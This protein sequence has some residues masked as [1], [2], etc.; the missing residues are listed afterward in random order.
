MDA[1]S[2]NATQFRNT[3]PPEIVYAAMGL[4]NLG[5]SYVQHARLLAASASYFA[6]G[7][8]AVNATSLADPAR[9]LFDTGRCISYQFIMRN[10]PDVVYAATERATDLFTA[11]VVAARRAV[12][13][14]YIVTLA[15]SLVVVAAFALLMCP[16][17]APPPR[18]ALPPSAPISPQQLRP[19]ALHT[20]RR[21]DNARSSLRAALRRRVL[22]MSAGTRAGSF[23]PSFRRVRAE[24]D[25]IMGLFLRIPKATVKILA[26]RKIKVRLNS[27]DEESEDEDDDADVDKAAAK[28]AA[29]A[30]KQEK[31][32]GEGGATYA[33]IPRR[34]CSPSA[35]SD[36]TRLRP[37]LIMSA[38]AQPAGL[39]LRERAAAGRPR[40][41][42]PRLNP[43]QGPWAW[44]P[45]GA[46]VAA[47]PNLATPDSHGQA[48]WT[49]GPARESVRRPSYLAAALAAVRLAFSSGRAAAYGPGPPSDRAAK[50]AP[51]PPPG[52]PSGKPG[53]PGGKG[54]APEAA[55]ARM[56]SFFRSLAV[57]YLAALALTAKTAYYTVLFGAIFG[58]GMRLT[59][60]LDDDAG[61]LRLACGRATLAARLAQLSREFVLSA[62]AQHG[63]VT[64]GLRGRVAAD[65]AALRG[66]HARLVSGGRPSYPPLADLTYRASCMRPERALCDLTS[67]IDRPAVSNGLDAALSY[68]LD[69]SAKADL[70]VADGVA[71][72]GAPPDALANP[73]FRFVWEIGLRDVMDGLRS[74]VALYR[75]AAAAAESALVPVHGALMGVTLAALAGMFVFLFRPMVTRLRD[76]TRRTR[77]MLQ[78][79]PDEVAE[80]VDAIKEY[81]DKCATEGA[82]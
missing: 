43:A 55:P 42:P 35:S 71:A 8:A 51:M 16:R 27:D 70:L 2:L 58:A 12:Q 53:Q 15:V 81:L 60:R 69:Q 26:R 78:M 77:R 5:E 18:P 74:A 19:R 40:G 46:A 57:Q 14:V 50:V 72:G 21:D 56:D 9:C 64:P 38:R 59:A 28:E 6:R 30:S 13:L 79:I 49:T 4:W 11:G 36:Q 48:A 22:I 23:G 65:A 32:G 75:E 66:A 29:A 31:A 1:P 67:S 76:E 82:A 52:G 61:D 24:R 41:Q 63:V 25:S 37:F 54:P 68:L 3:N 62:A 39:V 7:P 34:A 80:K 10:S 44:G 73:R 33:D 45:A 47:L 17:P 20:F